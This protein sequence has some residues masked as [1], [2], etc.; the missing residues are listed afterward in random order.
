MA[1]LSIDSKKW[2]L[3]SGIGG[4]LILINKLA[5]D[6]RLVKASHLPLGDLAQCNEAQFDKACAIAWDMWDKD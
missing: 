3:R 6:S 5:R 4:I 2:A 1:K